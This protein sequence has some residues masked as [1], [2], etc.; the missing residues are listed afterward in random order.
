MLAR[1]SIALLLAGSLSIPICYAQEEDSVPEKDS[2]AGLPKQYAA[3]HLV[4]SDTVSPDKKMA[5][6]YPKEDDEK[7]KDYLVSLKP[8]KILTALDTKWP[9]FAHESHGGLRAQWAAD[10]S[11]VLVTL[12]S[13]WGPGDV[14]LYE[15]QGGKVTRSTNLTDKVHELLKPDYD[16]VKPEPYN[17]EFDFIFDDDMVDT[18][19]GDAND[20]MPQ[21]FKLEGATV[22]VNAGATTDPKHIGGLKAWDAKF[23]G[24]WDIAQGKFT[25]QKVKRIFGGKRKDD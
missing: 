2:S 4:G 23:T 21:Q 9:Y 8:F 19:K 22:V 18:G 13:K 16:Q 3:T 7:G 15:I 10:N 25:E 24:T 11:T 20:E 14:F 6:I 12:D 5:V 17:D 1:F